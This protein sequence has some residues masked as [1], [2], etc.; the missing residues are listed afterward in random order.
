LTRPHPKV[1]ERKERDPSIGKVATV[2]RLSA[3]TV[4]LIAAYKGKWICKISR[5]PDMA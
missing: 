2:R 1:S 4:D 5:K 3:G